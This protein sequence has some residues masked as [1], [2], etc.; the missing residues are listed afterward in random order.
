MGQ[1]VLGQYLAELS[2]LKLLLT[3]QAGEGSASRAPVCQP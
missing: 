1:Y 2:K 3:R